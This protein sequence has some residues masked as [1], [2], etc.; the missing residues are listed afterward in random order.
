MLPSNSLALQGFPVNTFD[1][2]FFGLR[3]AKCPIHWPAH[4]LHQIFYGGIYVPPFNGGGDEL[5]VPFHYV[6]RGVQTSRALMSL[7]SQFT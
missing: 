4:S 3:L 2:Y 7:R 1:T 5:V 6:A